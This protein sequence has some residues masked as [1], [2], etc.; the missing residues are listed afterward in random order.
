MPEP[1]R[2]WEIRREWTLYD[3]EAVGEISGSFG[4]Y[5]IADATGA[6]LYVGYAG[7]HTLFGLQGC[8]AAHFGHRQA[9]PGPPGPME[10]AALYRYEVNSSYLGRWLEILGRYREEHGALPP[11]NIPEEEDMPTLPRFT[12]GL[13]HS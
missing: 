6:L 7:G 10:T 5:E 8:I 3:P 1:Y 11:G 2:P 9:V 13:R 4:V 12:G